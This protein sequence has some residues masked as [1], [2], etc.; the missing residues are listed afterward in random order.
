MEETHH[1][2]SPNTGQLS[3]ALITLVFIV[4]YVPPPFPYL[5]SSLAHLRKMDNS[6]REDS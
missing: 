2:Q 3:P 6:A 4:N 1:T 5:Q